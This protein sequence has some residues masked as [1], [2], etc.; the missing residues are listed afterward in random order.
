M[1]VVLNIVVR[2]LL[3]HFLV[4]NLITFLYTCNFG[5]FSA[6]APR[7][8]QLWLTGSACLNKIYLSIYT[9]IRANVF[10]AHIFGL[11]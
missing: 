9:P 6:H 4:N 8:N 2:T 10:V 3:K 5:F 11:I 1:S 7:G